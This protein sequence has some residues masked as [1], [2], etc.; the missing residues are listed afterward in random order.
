MKASALF[1]ATF[2]LIVVGCNRPSATDLF[3]KAREAQKAR[4]FPQALDGYA[5]VV[6]EYPQSAEAESSMFAIA[7]IRQMDTYQPAE[8]VNAYR[9]Y[10]ETYPDGVFSPEATFLIGYIY[11]NELHNLDSAGAAYRRFLGKYPKHELS[12]AAEKELQNLGK[13]PEEILQQTVPL[14]TQQ[15]QRAPNPAEKR[16]K[17][18]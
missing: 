13:S 1:A 8:A 6:Q 15:E 4:A 11:D 9:R 2:L 7:T 3:T 10:I 12:F 17:R 18:R 14:T 5:K 16:S